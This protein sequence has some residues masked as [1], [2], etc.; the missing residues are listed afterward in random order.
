MSAF[1]SSEISE[2]LVQTFEG[3]VPTSSWGEFSFFYNPESAL[4]RGTYFCTLKEKDGDNDKA[5]NLNRAAVF[6]VNFGLPSK[7]FE[8]VFGPRPLRP[9]K[10][11]TIDGPWNFSQLDVLM[12]HPIYAWMG[13]VCVLS[14]SSD[15]FEIMKPLLATAYD[16][17]VHSFNKRTRKLK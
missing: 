1:G 7:A 16:H 3:L 9:A 2:Y 11:N 10:G 6:R 12:P 14:P 4:P 17:A 5:S 13:W 8:G 15:T